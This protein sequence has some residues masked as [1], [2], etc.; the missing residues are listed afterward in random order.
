MRYIFALSV[1]VVFCVVVHDVRLSRLQQD[2]ENRI[3]H[4][5]NSR[6]EAI[7]REAAVRKKLADCQFEY[8]ESVINFVQVLGERRSF[9]DVVRRAA[10]EVL[11]ADSALQEVESSYVPQPPPTNPVEVRLAQAE[12]LVAEQ[13]ANARLEMKKS[14]LAYL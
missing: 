2:E 14:G 7:Q 10:R 3:V 4:D 11:V 13:V 1:A 9:D 12:S 8:I 5:P 6:L